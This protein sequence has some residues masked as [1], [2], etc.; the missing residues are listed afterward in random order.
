MFQ[1]RAFISFRVAFCSTWNSY[2]LKSYQMSFRFL[3]LGPC[4]LKLTGML[5]EWSPGDKVKKMSL[6]NSRAW[7]DQT[8]SR[9]F[10][11]AS[12]SILL[13]TWSIPTKISYCR[14]FSH[15]PNCVRLL[16]SFS[17]YLQ[18]MRFSL[19]S[20]QKLSCCHHIHL[21]NHH[22]CGP[23]AYCTTRYVCFRKRSNHTSRRSSIPPWTKHCFF[24]TW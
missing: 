5:V 9:L 19:F 20:L 11:S 2:Q 18:L 8:L 21:Q 22:Y 17:V 24:N 7:L 4:S 23:F 13:S 12:I 1:H 15:G 16:Q 3:I 14:P 6:S 10:Q